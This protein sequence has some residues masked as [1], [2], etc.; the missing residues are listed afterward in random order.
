MTDEK[1]KLEIVPKGDPTDVFN[2]LEALRKQSKITVQRKS[3]L[4]NVTVDRPPNNVYFRAHPS[5]EMQLDSSTIVRPKQGTTRP[6]YLVLP[7]MRSHPKLIQQV[8]WVTIALLSIWPE[9]GIMLWPVP[10]LGSRYLASAKSARAAFELS[11]E[12]WT[13]IVWNEGANDYNVETA[14][15]IDKE[16]V[17]PD[18]DFAS[19]LKIGFAD[20]VI[21]NEDHPYVRQLRGLAD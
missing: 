9:G 19:L 4:I 8:R 12:H 17:W 1:P 18:K 3:I 20:K 15:N 2:N 21:D 16:P 14:E 6:Y 13:Q 10:I 5:P 7:H 11:Q